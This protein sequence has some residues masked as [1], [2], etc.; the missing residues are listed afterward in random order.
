MICHPGAIRANSLML[1]IY[2]RH[3]EGT[4]VSPITKGGA[5]RCNAQLV[6]NKTLTTGPLQAHMRR[7]HGRDASGKLK[8]AFRSEN[9]RKIVD[10][11][12]QDYLY[13]AAMATNL[14]HC[15]FNRHHSHSLLASARG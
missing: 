8:F 5:P 15:F 4:G 7:V 12:V 11:P 9:S 14:R 13:Q 10:C 2:K 3:H 1:A 6:C